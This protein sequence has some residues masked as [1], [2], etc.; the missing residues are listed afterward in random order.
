M[1][2]H[3][4]RCYDSPEEANVGDHPMVG[5]NVRFL[6][7]LE[8]GVATEPPTDDPGH[9][10]IFGKKTASTKKKLA[11]HATWVIPPENR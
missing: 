6:R 2:A 4:A 3:R 7:G 9:L 1:S 5:L 8:L 11:R 10:W